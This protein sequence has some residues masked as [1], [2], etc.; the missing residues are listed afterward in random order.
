MYAL[1]S[2]LRTL[3]F[4][5]A[6]FSDSLAALEASSRTWKLDPASNNSWNTAINWARAP[7][8]NSPSDMAT[9][10]ISNTPRASI[11]RARQD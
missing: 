9:L 7:V 11:H 6:L 5:A 10:E 3:L 8:S 2:S 4:D 1:R